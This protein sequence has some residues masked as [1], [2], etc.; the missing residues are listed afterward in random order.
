MPLLPLMKAECRRDTSKSRPSPDTSRTRSTLLDSRVHEEVHL[1]SHSPAI[2]SS[3]L[4]GLIC[5]LIFYVFSAV[6]SAMIFDEA[7]ADLPEYQSLG[8]GMNTLSAFVGGLIFAKF[9][10][11]GAVMAG[12]DITPTVFMVEA[13]RGISTSICTNGT[14]SCDPEEK[15]AILPTVL[16][17]IWLM[18]AISGA[19]FYGLGRFR[20][21]SIVGYMPAN[22]TGAFL[23]CIGYKVMYYAIQ[24]ACGHKIKWFTKH[25][26]YLSVVFG[27]WHPEYYHKATSSWK[28]GWMLIT[29][30]LGI[31]LPLYYLKRK[32]I[33]KP[34]TWLI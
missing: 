21:T 15:K 30:A 34:S 25:D 13:A 14:S 24:V 20:L 17:A 27:S 3:I 9:S 2:V 33:G 11:C 28:G 6:F 7:G 8:V 31:G 26:K 19:F 29:P 23:S 12:P 16:V 22:V 18:T 32:H 5:G 4:S 10:G 1:V